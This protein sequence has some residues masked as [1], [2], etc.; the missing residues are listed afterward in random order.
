MCNRWCAVLAN[1][2]GFADVALCWGDN[3]HGQLGNL[4]TADSTTPVLV[5][6]G[7]LPAQGIT[8]L[9][10]GASFTCAVGNGGVVD[11]WGYNASGQLGDGTTTGSTRFGTPYVPLS[12]PT[13]ISAGSGYAC[14]IVSG[15]PSCWGDNASGRLGDGTESPSSLPVTVMG[16]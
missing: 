6:T 5:S 7:F 15:V 14:A 8:A 3:V 1:R 10:A 4:T 12:T 16:L 11:C 13:A 2:S 9:S